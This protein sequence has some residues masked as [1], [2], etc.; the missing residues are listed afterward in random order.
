MREGKGFLFIKKRK[1]KILSRN[2]SGKVKAFVF[3]RD[4]SK[5]VY[6]GSAE[7]LEIDH[8]I[9]ITKSGSNSER[10][11]QLVCL[12]CNRAKYNHIDDDFLK[13]PKKQRKKNKKSSN[14]L[15][16]NDILIPIGIINK[17]NWE[18]ETP[19][20]GRRYTRG[21]VGGLF[22]F[23]GEENKGFINL[24]RFNDKEVKLKIPI[25]VYR[26]YLWENDFPINYEI[27]IIDSSFMD[28]KEDQEGLFLWKREESEE[29]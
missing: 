23:E 2:I 19:L 1:N 25:P 22:L 14:T 29:K 11:I 28:V 27:I 8:I 12:D 24:Y 10:N 16:V 18:L 21:G 9:P 6:C 13:I 5:C 3:E 26:G 4:K 15:L 17:L 20:E 7:N